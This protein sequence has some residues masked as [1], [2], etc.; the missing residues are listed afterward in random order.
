MKTL[1]NTDDL[2]IHLHK[3]GIKF[4]IIQEDNAKTFLNQSNYYLKLGSYRCNYEKITE[5][6]RN[7]EYRD[8]EF[9]YLVE[10][11]KLDM[12]MRYLIMELC[13]DIEHSLKVILL[14]K[15]ENNPN[16]DGYKIINK[17]V[18]DNKNVLENISTH[19][20]SEYCRNLIEKYYP[21]FPIWVFVEI[22]SFGTLRKLCW[23]YGKEYDD[24]IID[25]RLLNS[26]RDLRNA[27]AH[28]NC[29][30]NNLKNTNNTPL[31]TIVNY[32]KTIDG[33]GNTARNKKLKNKFVYDFTTLIYVYNKIIKSDKLKEKQINKLDFLLNN[34]FNENI[35]YFK[36][37]YLITSTFDFLRK[38]VDSV[39]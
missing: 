21:N 25:S 37:N 31:N 8:L 36:N 19:K 38:I 18:A 15:V 20:S 32:V 34:R 10:L 13:L 17:F 7:G 2:I 28:N 5:G 26:V 22:V 11:S 35:S 1:L 4:N 39:K 12:Y 29:L 27:T 30:L 3:K 23:F 16:E 14:N 24:N 33:I 9:A 6:K